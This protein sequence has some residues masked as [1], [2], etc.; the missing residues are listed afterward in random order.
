MKFHQMAFYVALLF[1]CTTAELLTEEDHVLDS[2]VKLDSVD[3]AP[4]IQN[5]SEEDVRQKREVGETKHKREKGKGPRGK[6]KSSNGKGREKSSNI[7]KRK[8]KPSDR[9]GK[10][11]IKQKSSGGNG[12]GKSTKKSK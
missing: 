8:R 2:D 12:K 7:S 9:K 4:E 5:Y 6:R 11:K 10:G 1:A 3:L